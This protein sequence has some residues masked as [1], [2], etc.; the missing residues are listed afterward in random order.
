MDIFYGVDPIIHAQDVPNDSSGSGLDSLD[1]DDD[2]VVREI[3]A[4]V[5]Y[6]AHAYFNLG[7]TLSSKMECEIAYFIQSL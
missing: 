2:H 3:A 7:I 6:F 4:R 5:V 1:D